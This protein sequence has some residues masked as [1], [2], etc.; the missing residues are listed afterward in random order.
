MTAVH[1]LFLVGIQSSLI[2]SLSASWF[3]HIDLSFLVQT[4][5]VWMTRSTWILYP[6]SSVNIPYPPWWLSSDEEN[7]ENHLENTYKVLQRTSFRP[8]LDSKSIWFFFKWKFLLMRKKPNCYSCKH[9]ERRRSG[10]EKRSTGVQSKRA[11]GHGFPN[12]PRP[13]FYV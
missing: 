2:S 6:P 9:A 7:K 4:V 5:H 3:L 1:C 11:H 12:D 13:L 10:K 8:S